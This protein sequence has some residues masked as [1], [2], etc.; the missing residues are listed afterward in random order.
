M[1]GLDEATQQ[2]RL[3][4]DR[5]TQPTPSPL[6]GGGPTGTQGSTTI[7]IYRSPFRVCV[8]RVSLQLILRLCSH[9]VLDS[10]I[11]KP[12]LSL[13]GRG[14]RL[15]PVLGHRGSL[16]PTGCQMTPSDGSWVK[17]QS[18]RIAEYNLKYIGITLTKHVKD[19]LLTGTSTL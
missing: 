16:H 7:G 14:S 1:S 15:H 13:F 3:E 8:G 10:W 6:S 17:H 4:S 5:E 2:C 19:C 11:L 9:G 18:M 12:F